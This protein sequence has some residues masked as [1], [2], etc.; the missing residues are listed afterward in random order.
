MSLR[1]K[2]AWAEFQR[3]RLVDVEGSWFDIHFTAEPDMDEKGRWVC[4]V[5]RMAQHST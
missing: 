5:E 4:P 2:E 3:G 1:E